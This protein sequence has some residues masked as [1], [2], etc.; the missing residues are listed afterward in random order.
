MPEEQDGQ[1]PP[2]GSEPQGS[3]G[4]PPENT[5]PP[6][7]PAVYQNLVNYYNEVNPFVEK[8][9]PYYEDISRY[10]E[11]EQARS[12][13]QNAWKSYESIA[14]KEDIPSWA[15]ELKAQN[16]E[17]TKFIKE[18]REQMR[19][20]QVGRHIDG[21]AGTHPQLYADNGKLIKELKTDYESLVGDKGTV[22]GFG[23]YVERMVRFLPQE[24]QTETPSVSKPKSPPRSLRGDSSLPG[25]TDVQKP[26]FSAGR[27]GLNERRAYLKGQLRKAAAKDAGQAS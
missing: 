25:V 17:T 26:Q 21:L 16:E 12:L 14:P 18:Q 19:I 2:A 9:R 24:K 5:Q 23:Q 3:S 15:K 27:E 10:I 20:A 4:V 6:I 1:T 8:A 13:A 11:D 7:D 22:E